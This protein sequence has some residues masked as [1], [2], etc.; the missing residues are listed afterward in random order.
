[1]LYA[2]M[3]YMYEGAT[4]TLKFLF[5]ASNADEAERKAYGWSRYHGFVAGMVFARPASHKEQKLTGYI[6]D[7]WVQAYV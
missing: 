4:P 2:M 6:H 1:M 7:E 3:M 5:H